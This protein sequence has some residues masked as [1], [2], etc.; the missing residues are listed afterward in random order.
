MVNSFFFF[1]KRLICNYFRSTTGNKYAQHIFVLPLT[2][3][4]KTNDVQSDFSSFSS[5]RFFYVLLLLSLVR[6]WHWDFSSFIWLSVSL[7]LSNYIE[8]WR[9][10]RKYIKLPICYNLQFFSSFSS[11]PEIPIGR[12]CILAEEKYIFDDLP[13]STDDCH[14]NWILYIV[15][16]PLIENTTISYLF[17]TKKWK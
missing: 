9:S 12:I 4:S 8:Y 7:C 6:S 1:W 5:E 13:R 17:Q 15:H 3:E 14:I 11:S 2:K 10:Q 16:S